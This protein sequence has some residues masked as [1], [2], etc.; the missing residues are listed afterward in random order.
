MKINGK[1]DFS[2][3]FQEIQIYT[4]IYLTLPVTVA[5]FFH[6][7]CLQLGDLY[8]KLQLPFWM[9]TYVGLENGQTATTVDGSEIPRPTTWDVY[10]TL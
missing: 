6:W 4:L 2:C 7:D 8:I 5:F 10:K 9:S 1:N 3:Y